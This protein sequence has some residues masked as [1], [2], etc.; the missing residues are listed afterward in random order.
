MAKLAETLVIEYFNRA[1]YATVQG[2]KKGYN[3]WDLLAIRIA[4]G[5]PE[6]VHV[7]VQVSFDPIGFLSANNAKK[8]TDEQL[9]A[10][11]EKWFAKKFAN[12]KLKTIHE[13]FYKGNWSNCFVYGEIRDKR[14]LGFLSKRKVKLIPFHDVLDTLCNIRPQKVPFTAEGKD[15]VE[16]IR[17]VQRRFHCEP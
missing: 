11:M 3:E 7:E 13:A 8:R 1:G 10:D 15:L 14:E 12:E 6:A 9:E 4:S 17:N 16:I 2:I 5:K